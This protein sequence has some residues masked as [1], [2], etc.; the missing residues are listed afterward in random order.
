MRVSRL[1]AQS[2]ETHPVEYCYLQDDVLNCGN[3]FSV[4]REIMA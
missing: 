3:P 1:C 4:A 2:L